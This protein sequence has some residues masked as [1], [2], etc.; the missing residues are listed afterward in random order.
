ML[1]RRALAVAA[2]SAALGTGLAATPAAAGNSA[3]GPGGSDVSA[4][5][6]TRTTSRGG[7]VRECYRASCDVVMQTYA[8]ESLYWHHN[9]RNPA[10]N[11][12]YYVRYTT[13]NGRPHDFYGW[14]YC[15]NVTAHC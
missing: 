13:G 4:A 3:A 10:G 11:L 7:P 5:S 12:W 9:A 14:I 6:W 1:I 15:G 2:V 8:G